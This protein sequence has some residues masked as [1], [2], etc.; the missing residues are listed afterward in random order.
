[1]KY[2]SYVDPFLGNGEIDLPS[3]TYPASTWHF[4]KG[5]TGNTNSGAVL[6]F[7]K[8]SA[9]G[10]TGGYPCGIGINDV[11]SGEPI[12]KIDP[13]PRFVGIAHFAQSGTGGIG[14]YYN[15]A[16]CHPFTQVPDFQPRDVVRQTA[17]PGYY[18]VTVDGVTAETTVSRKA[19]VSR[20]TFTEDG[21]IAVDF[22][23]DGLRNPH[24]RGKARGTVTRSAPDRLSACIMLSGIPLWF[25]MQITG[26]RV[27]ELFFGEDAVTGNELAVKED[28]SFRFGGV[29]GTG[30]RCELRLAVSPISAEKAREDLAC[31]TRGFDEIAAAADAEWE[32]VLSRIEI[33]TDDEREKRI[34]YSN[35]YHTLVKPADLTGEAFLAEDPD[36]P[37]TVDIAT[38]WDIYKTQLPMLFTLYPDVSAK[39]LNT[40]RIWGDR[41]GT[42][43][44]CLLLSGRLNIESKQ[45]RMLAEYAV[46][47]AYWRGVPADYRRLLELSEKDGKRYEDYFTDKGCEMA[48]HT[49]DM[50]EAYNSLALVAKAMGENR[51]AEDFAENGK[52][53]KTAFGSDGMMRA[54]S[55]YY[56]GNRYNYSFRPMHDSA[57]RIALAGPEKMKAEALRFFGFT[58][59][60]DFSSRFEGFNNETD[61][62]APYFLHE[63]GLRDEMCEVLTSGVDS[64]FTEGIGG[65]PG[66]AD[67][68]GLT[69]CY[70][71]DV[72]GVWP[73]S[74]QD[75]MIVGTPRYRR[76]VLHLP[77]GDFTVVREGGG[78]YT[79]SAE[80]NGSPLPAME[81]PA[82]GIRPGGVLRVFMKETR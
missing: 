74:G 53:W 70:L 62:E 29:I 34:F 33:E 11:N 52:R 22:G 58:D 46:C 76:A 9:Q 81:F 60:E 78:I 2:T 20:Y 68:G 7:S 71:W 6:P 77:D 44:H 56:E 59:G 31:E 41:F 80:L 26:G 35:L 65:I 47:D 16:L 27:K 15:Y 30:K 43:P 5:L 45:A 14:T 69:A 10:Y 23:N 3:P 67:S 17:K 72:I 12:R 38:M 42:L 37:F 55:D 1:M 75:R 57:A 63:L 21:G 4:I 51:L 25:E 61:M 49:V 8:Y 19:A 13:S 54:D 39:L 50:A 82:A 40:F 24:L 36:Q 28:T 32:E 66:N 79:A 64:M 73:V 48:S 18:A